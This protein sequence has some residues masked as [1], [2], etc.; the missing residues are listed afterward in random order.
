[1]KDIEYVAEKSKMNKLELLKIADKIKAKEYIRLSF[2][3]NE[4]S[5][6]QIFC[7]FIS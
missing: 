7:F 1:M 2:I 3:S 4:Y 5:K 6:K